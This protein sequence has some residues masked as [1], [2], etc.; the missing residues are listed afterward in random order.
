MLH[1]WVLNADGGSYRVAIGGDLVAARITCASA[2]PNPGDGRTSFTGGGGYRNVV[3]EANDVV[4]IQFFSQLSGDNQDGC[5]IAS[6]RNA[7]ERAEHCLTRMLPTARHIVNW[8]RVEIHRH[9]DL[10]AAPACRGSRSAN[11]AFQFDRDSIFMNETVKNYCA[12]AGLVFTRCR[13][14]RKNDQA[15]VEQKNGAV[16]RHAVGY[17]R[18]RDWRRPRH[19]RGC[20]RRCDYL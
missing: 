14:Y 16:V 5:R 15:W 3:P 18:Y 20:I 9:L 12:E 6:S 17:R 10:G 11:P 4:K 7:P 2:G 8:H 13:P 1:I 19:S